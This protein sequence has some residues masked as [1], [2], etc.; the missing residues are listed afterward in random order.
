MRFWI[1]SRWLLA[2]GITYTLCSA[3]HILIG[4]FGT[5]YFF[6]LNNFMQGHN[7]LWFLSFPQS[8]LF[9]TP[10][11]LTSDLTQGFKPSLQFG[12]FLFKSV[13]VLLMFRQF[14]PSLLNG[15]PYFINFL[16]SFSWKNMHVFELFEHI[17]K[18]C[19]ELS[20]GGPSKLILLGT[21]AVG[22]VIWGGNG[23]SWVTASFLLLL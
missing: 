12:F 16:I 22:L 23:L 10:T 14:C 2:L 5:C 21:I 11:S 9:P 18:H 20:F 17:C 15:Y 6:F 8:L 4:L 13:C 1:L 19:F 3:I 7:A